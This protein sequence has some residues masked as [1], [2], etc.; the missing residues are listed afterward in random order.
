MD[1]PP[2]V[3]LARFRCAAQET[4]LMERPISPICPR[5]LISR[6]IWQY[7]PTMRHIGTIKLASEVVTL[8]ATESLNSVSQTFAGCF[9]TPPLYHW[10]QPVKENKRNAKENQTQVV[11][12]KNWI[13]L[14]WKFC[15]ERK[16]IYFTCD[17]SLFSW[18]TESHRTKWNGRH[19]WISFKF[20]KN[21]NFPFLSYQG[22]KKA[23]YIDS[24]H[25][26]TLSS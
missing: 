24:V 12:R 23:I 10:C 26:K 13:E 17:Y 6:K 11:R 25:Q 4:R 14:N 15:K 1:C 9:R 22:N 18:P 8:K 21:L 5:R 16:C 3:A 20:Q 2:L 19:Y 7:R